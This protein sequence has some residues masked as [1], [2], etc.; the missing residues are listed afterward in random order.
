MLLLLHHGNSGDKVVEGCRCRDRT[1]LTSE[2][3]I[4]N[5]PSLLFCFRR[6][7]SRSATTHKYA[8]PGVAGVSKGI[9]LG[10]S[11]FLRLSL[12]PDSPSL[13]RRPSGTFSLLNIPPLS[14][15]TARKEGVAVG[16]RRGEIA[17]IEDYLTF[18]GLLGWLL[19]RV[20]SS[21]RSL[22]FATA[23]IYNEGSEMPHNSVGPDICRNAREA[24]SPDT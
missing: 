17:R 14:L 4:G 22:V 1:T 23:G 5:C 11:R 12:F 16:G 24:P 6:L 3:T 10:L 21:P 2:L 13:V 18:A 20:T 8:G 7:L 19:L 15:L 9:K